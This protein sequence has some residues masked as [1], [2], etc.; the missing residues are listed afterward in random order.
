MYEPLQL[1]VLAHDVVQLS[2]TFLGFTKAHSHA[3]LLLEPVGVLDQELLGQNPRAK[4]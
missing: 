1:A 2:C 4:L 3:E